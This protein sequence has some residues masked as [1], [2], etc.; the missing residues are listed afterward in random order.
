MKHRAHSPRRKESIITICV[1]IHN[2]VTQHF[3]ILC[4]SSITMATALQTMSDDSS[5]LL[6]LGDTSKALEL[7]RICVQPFLSPGKCPDSSVRC[8][9][10]I[11][12]TT[13]Q[14]LC[15][16]LHKGDKRTNNEYSGSCWS[17][18]LQRLSVGSVCTVVASGR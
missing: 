15:L 8:S 3:T 5:S 9:G 16:V 7:T 18:F 14:F 12:G 4:T 6:P 1:R 10:M 17:C 11:P 2:T 13:R